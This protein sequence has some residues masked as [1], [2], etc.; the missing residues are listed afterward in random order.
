MTKYLVKCHGYSDFNTEVDSVECI[1]T[2][3]VAS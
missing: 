1:K 3:H 2:S